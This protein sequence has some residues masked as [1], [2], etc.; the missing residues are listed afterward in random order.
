MKQARPGRRENLDLRLLN[1]PT[2][3]HRS[4]ILVFPRFFSESE[5]GLAQTMPEETPAQS[6]TFLQADLKSSRSCTLLALHART[7]VVQLDEPPKFW[8]DLHQIYPR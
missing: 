3:F 8:Y 7:S 6:S 5:K 2:C 4:Q 1:I